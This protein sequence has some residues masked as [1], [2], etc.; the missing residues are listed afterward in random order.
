[1]S[2]ILKLICDIIEHELDIKGQVWIY[3]NKINIPNDDKLYVIVSFLSEKIIGNNLKYEPND[4]GGL[5]EIAT[6]NTMAS[7]TIDILSRGTAA[8]DRKAEVLMALF[9]TYSQQEQE[10]N[11]FN[12]ARNG[13]NITNVSEAEG[14]AIPYR[15][16]LTFNAT[17]ATAKTKAV[18]YYD[19]FT[20][21]LITD[22]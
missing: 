8:R 5:N 6:V 4:N 10:A 7:V 22:K 20:K 11:G 13:F 2:K 18:D 14:A 3:N 15:Y 16:N 12:I 9:S 21:E 17:Y 1:M 19:T